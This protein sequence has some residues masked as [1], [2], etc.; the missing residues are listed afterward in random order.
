MLL[1]WVGP[2]VGLK[3]WPKADFFGRLDV[4]YDQKD[5]KQV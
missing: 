2:K 5:K 4:L 3:E 1:K